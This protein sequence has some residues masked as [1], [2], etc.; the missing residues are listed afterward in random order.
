MTKRGGNTGNPERANPNAPRKTESTSTRPQPRL[1]SEYRSK[2][3]RESVVQ[4]WL[5]LGTAVLLGTI[6]VV[7]LIAFIADSI[8]RPA[9]TVAVVNGE[10]ISVA[11]FE[12]RV[13][14]ERALINQRINDGLDLYR[15][16]GLSDDQAIQQIQQQEP[17]VTFLNEIQVPDQLGNRVLNDM[18]T[19]V[20]IEQEAARLGITVD[21]AAVEAQIQPLFGYDPETA[22]LPPTE[23]PEPTVTPTPFVS[24]TPTLTPTATLTPEFTPTPSVTP[25]ASATPTVTP[26]PTER[27]ETYQQERGDYFGGIASQAGVSQDDVRAYFEQQALREAVR[28]ALTPEITESGTFV[29]AR[30]MLLESEDDAQAA[31]LALGSGESFAELARAIST[32]TASGNLG[33]EL[34]WA[35]VTNY[36]PPFAEAAR[37]AD[38][39]AIVGPVES[40]FG[41]HVIQVRGREERPLEED[42]I[43]T[44]REQAFERYLETLRDAETTNIELFD[45]WT[46]NVPEEPR[47]V[48]R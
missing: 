28:D 15:S 35:P 20:L 19:D 14:L 48:L 33:G 30:H 3:E 38:I 32:D 46:A 26:N 7:L 2:A 39:G 5:I 16:F 29:N 42:Q 21:E 1:L 10:S 47:L 12:R 23:T 18:V 27:A 6:V 34:G 17:F 36:V 25:V 22:G 31:I 43:E 8:I 37:A 9:Q 45:V 11:Q 41:F 40:D 24:P 13:R 4:R 44:A